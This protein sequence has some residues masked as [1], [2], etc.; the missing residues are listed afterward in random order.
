MAEAPASSGSQGSPGCAEQEGDAGTAGGGGSA[1]SAPSAREHDMYLPVA[2]IGR[3]MKRVL[4]ANAKIAKDAKDI[5]QECVSEFIS[6]ITSEASDK[7]HRDKR[8]T[9]NGDDLLWAMTILG[10]ENYI[11]P[12]K[13]YLQRF[14]ELEGDNRISTGNHGG[15]EDSLTKDVNGSA[16]IA[17]VQL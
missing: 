11:E 13:I 16:S 7:C 15:P 4:P 6:F 12:L 3:I 8:K 5:V 14:R 2:N 9:V 1:I 17:N 10:F